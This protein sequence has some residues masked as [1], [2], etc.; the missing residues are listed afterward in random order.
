VDHIHVITERR[1]RGTPLLQQLAVWPFECH[2]V[3][4]IQSTPVTGGKA[5][6][7]KRLLLCASLRYEVLQLRSAA[8]ARKKRSANR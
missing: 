2:P 5:G 7:L 8:F 3:W 6:N 4:S 1:R